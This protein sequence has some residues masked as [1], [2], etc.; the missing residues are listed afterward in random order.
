MRNR[1]KK[2]ME[3]GEISKLTKATL[4]EKKR[5]VIKD[6]IASGKIKSENS[7]V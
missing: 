5:E 2:E 1:L 4:G 7:K 6:W 3:K